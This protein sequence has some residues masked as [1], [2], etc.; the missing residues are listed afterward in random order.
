MSWTAF[1]VRPLFWIA[2]SIAIII[3]MFLYG[4]YLVRDNTLLADAQRRLSA[5]TRDLD[6]LQTAKT[7]L[8]AELEQR[9][10]EINEKDRQIA[11]VR[12]DLDQKGRDVAELTE[13]VARRD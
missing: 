4:M 2:F 12:G 10:R 8:S 13:Q 1:L 6:D 5:L 3:A 11:E 9:I 7:S